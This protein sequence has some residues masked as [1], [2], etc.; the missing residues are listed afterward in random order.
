LIPV[1]PGRELEKLEPSRKATTARWFTHNTTVEVVF[2][3]T[4]TMQSDSNP[5]HLHGH[6]FFVLAQGCGNYESTTWWTR[7]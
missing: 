1:V 6:D 4:A 7:Y 3:S 5:M 2:Q